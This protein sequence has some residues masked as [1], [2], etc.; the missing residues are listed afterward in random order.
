MAYRL[1]SS[2][3]FTAEF[4]AV[5]E[6]Q[7][8]KAIGYLEDHPDGEHEAVH[9]AR[10][11]FKRVRALYRLVQPDAPDFRARENAR[12]RETARSLS[13][14]RD[15]TALVETV[16]YL[17]DFAASPEEEAALKTARDALTAR[18][19]HIAEEEHDLPAKMAAAVENCRKAIDALEALELPDAPRK[20]ARRLGKAW[21]KQARKARAA[22]TACETEPGAETF[23]EL[24]KSGQTY[25]MHLSLLR[26][27]WPSAMKAK[28]AEAKAL[29]DL[30]GHEHDLS[31]LTQLVNEEPEIVG[32]G[33][34][35]AR[36]LAAII[37][38]Q[39]MLRQ[40]ALPMAQSVFADDAGAEAAMI[41]LLWE[42]AATAGAGDKPKRR[43][44]AE[45]ARKREEK[46]VE[47]T[48]LHG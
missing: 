37:T 7:L 23:H 15:A 45:K 44:G 32:D 18:R 41:R 21:R 33:E 2:K 9:D 47:E 46:P 14:V 19:N 26:E 22:L 10:K 48:A 38:R 29:V 5:S 28:Q 39:Q 24:R 1:R 36:L 25:W 6:D 4:R 35:L 12:I 3:P 30:L 34:T 8:K 27:A 17:L 43:N 11:R 42:R 13:A 20:T 40:D 16:G 31:V